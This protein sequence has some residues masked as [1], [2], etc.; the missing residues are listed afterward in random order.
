ML[1]S[2]TKDIKPSQDLFGQYDGRASGF[3]YTPLPS[4]SGNCDGG[5]LTLHDKG[6]NK[7]HIFAYCNS[8]NPSIL[9]RFDDLIIRKSRIDSVK[10]FYFPYGTSYSKNILYGIFNQTS[11]KEVAYILYDKTNTATNPPRSYQETFY[12]YIPFMISSNTK[13]TLINYFGQR[14]MKEVVE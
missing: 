8:N 14:I 1:M 4:G 10:I 6:N 11:G 9:P 3:G 7:V 5:G 12:V 13:D 2:C